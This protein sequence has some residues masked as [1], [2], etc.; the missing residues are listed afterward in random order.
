MKKALFL[1]ALFPLFVNAQIKFEDGTWKETLSKAKAEN[2][3]IFL[4]AYTTW[5]EPCKVLE[6]Y[7]FTDLE[8]ANF[9]N[10]NFINMRLDMEDY[11]GIDLAEKYNV[12][13]YPTL[14]FINGD[15]ELI[16]RGCSA[17]EAQE[18]L[19]L[20][21]TALNEKGN[22]SAYEKELVNGND[23]TDFL[24]DYL[25]LLESVC[26]DGEKFAKEYL[27][28]LELNDLKTE[29]GW[30]VFAGFQWDIYSKEFQHLLKNQSELEKTVGLREVNAK[31]YD[32]YLSQYQ[33]IYEAEE[34]HEFGMRA[35]LHSINPTSFLGADTLKA[36]MNL[37]YSEVTE[38]WKEYGTYAT[39]LVR[40]TGLDDP[41]ELNELAWK[42]YLYIEDKNQLEIAS[43][44][45]KL[46]VDVIGEPSPIDT[47]ASLLYKLGNTK[48][49]ILLEEKALE[50][51]KELYEDVSHYQHQLAKFKGE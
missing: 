15:G 1:I 16:H 29:S 36:M 27:S 12:T 45:A 5:C 38:N 48:K 22:L 18:F 42:F 26:L 43:S 11:P 3:I 40:I 24:I 50:L 14:L 13:L 8:V 49:A 20:G 25:D 37:H 33:E 7:T 19:A 47:Y 30:A 6:K 41:E 31:I 44:W 2:K 51:A 34:L 21:K 39:E 4:D 28:K 23:S 9:Y 32:T 35:L 17:M 46:A 10:D